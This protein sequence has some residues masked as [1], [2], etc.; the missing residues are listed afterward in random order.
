MTH[1]A[2]LQELKYIANSMDKYG[3]LGSLSPMVREAA[4]RLRKAEEFIDTVAWRAGVW[5]EADTLA[6][7]AD[8]RGVTVQELLR[9]M[10]GC[11]AMTDDTTRVVDAWPASSFDARIRDCLMMLYLHGAVTDAEFA[12]IKVRLQVIVEHRER[13]AK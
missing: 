12:K 5:S 13:L 2:F 3:G 6:N 11:R 4:D 1:N 10:E 9:Q 7:V 8:Y